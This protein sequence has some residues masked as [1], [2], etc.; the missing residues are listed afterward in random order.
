MM[1]SKSRGRGA[2][3]GVI[4]AAVVAGGCVA[5]CANQDPPG[6]GGGGGAGGGGPG[7]DEPG[8]GG[9]TGGNGAVGGGGATGGDGA[10][11]G[12]GATGGDGAAGGGGAGGDEP[13]DTAVGG[14]G[15]GDGAAGGGGSGAGA[16]APAG[17]RSCG[18]GGLAKEPLCGPEGISCCDSRLVPGGTFN[19]HFDGVN[20]IDDSYPA[21]V[22]SFLLDTYEVTVGRFRA[23]VEAGQGTRASAPEEGA[24]QHPEVP[25]SG[26]S[27]DWNHWF[28]EDTAALKEAVL[29]CYAD[30][31]VSTW[32]DEVGPNEDLPMN[33]ITWAEAFAFCVWD[34]GRL[35]TITELNYAA[36][37]GDEHRVYPWGQGIDP[38]RASYGCIADGSPAQ[39]CALSDIL[40]VGSR[41]AGAGR[42]GQQDLSGGMEE[43]TRD[44]SG[45]LS[46]T[47]PVPCVDCIILERPSEGFYLQTHG[48]NYREGELVLQAA[49]Q[50]I[51]RSPGRYSWSGV[52]CARTPPPAE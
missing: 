4:A 40:P 37:G 51:Y 23:F 39:E 32:T 47:L 19:R 13:G 24:G 38:S 35:P 30:P 16:G 48:G 15:A 44:W 45:T 34:G 49:S 26:W 52:R 33:C 36:S 8:G 11:G 50:G 3:F 10:A 7:G 17:P 2:W 28:E 25:G 9:A 14:G 12:G 27:A 6:K 41:P 29:R 42:W 22:S 43:F 21:T 18:S 31:E 5:A 20:Y 1:T 46:V